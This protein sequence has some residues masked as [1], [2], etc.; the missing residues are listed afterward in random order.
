MKDLSNRRR[1][2]S[3]WTPL[4]TFALRPSLPMVSVTSVITVTSAAAL[5]VAGR[6]LYA[7]TRY[8][9]M[10]HFNLMALPHLAQL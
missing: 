9:L 10:F 2:E 5:G 3:S 4:V 1:P 8:H 6:L 7:V